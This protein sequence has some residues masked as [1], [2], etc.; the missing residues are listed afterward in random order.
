MHALATKQK[1]LLE[2][3]AFVS[4]QVPSQKVIQAAQETNVSTL[5]GY[6]IKQGGGGNAFNPLG[7]RNWKQRYFILTSGRLIYAKTKDDYERG[8]IIKELQIPGYDFHSRPTDLISSPV[9]RISAPFCSCRVEP[10]VDAG[11]GF[12]IIPPQSG[13]HVYEL[14]RGLF[15]KN[16]RK[17]SSYADNGR[18]FKLRA[19]SIEERDNWMKALRASAG[20]YK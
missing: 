19:L 4:V 10:S 2:E 12:D 9:S 20:G 8:R 6:L 5:Q 3:A 17:K 11:E 15:D 14:Q 1:Q 7:R 13:S 18:V 16:S